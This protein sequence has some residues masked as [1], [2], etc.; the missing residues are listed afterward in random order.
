MSAKT[1]KATE[2]CWV[3]ID[4]DWVVG[5]FVR[6]VGRDISHSFSLCLY[7]IN[8]R[9]AFFRTYRLVCPAASFFTNIDM[10]KTVFNT[11]P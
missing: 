10:A 5:S 8:L 7:I 2:A 4:F 6:A 11:K 9:V 3:R 1:D